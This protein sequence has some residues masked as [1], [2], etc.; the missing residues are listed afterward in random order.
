[1]QRKEN[2][3]FASAFPQSTHQIVLHG[4]GLCCGKAG[5]PPHRN[6]VSVGHGGGGHAPTLR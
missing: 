5:G 6:L 1:M 3:P 4:L 2:P